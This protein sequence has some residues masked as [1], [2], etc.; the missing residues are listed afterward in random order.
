MHANTYSDVSLL[1]KRS[2]WPFFM[3]MEHVWDI[4]HQKKDAAA[5][6]NRRKLQQ[7]SNVKT[8]ASNFTIQILLA[9]SA[10]RA[11]C[12]RQNLEKIK[13]QQQDKLSK[14]YPSNPKE[15]KQSLDERHVYFKKLSLK[16]FLS[17]QFNDY[18][19]IMVDLIVNEVGGV[20][21]DTKS[22]VHHEY[23]IVSPPC[24][25]SILAEKG[26]FTII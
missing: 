17:H 14:W 24:A 26:V 5:L 12:I 4:L 9:Y 10:S 22:S 7:S 2:W 11:G 15:E 18:K 20:D 3:Q 13:C 25:N 23:L 21:R 6:C 1:S 8:F 19:Q 16:Y